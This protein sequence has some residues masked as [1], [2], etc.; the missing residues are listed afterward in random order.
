M[1][2]DLNQGISGKY[3]ILKIFHHPKKLKSLLANK[4]LSP[5]YVRVKPTNRCNHNCY[6]CLYHPEFSGTHQSIDKRDKIP[7]EKMLEILDDFKSMGVKAVTYSGGGEP[8]THPNITE[9]LEE[10]LKKKIRLSMITN[11]QDLEGKS[12]ELL[13]NADWIRVSLDYHNDKL[14]SKIRQKPK[15]DFYKVKKN[16]EEFVRKKKPSCDLGVN[17]VI[18]E[19]NFEEL[20][21]IAKFCKSIGVNN[22]RFSPFQRFSEESFLD[23]HNKIKIRA[24]GQIEKAKE[25]Q[26]KKISIG[27]TYKR[28]F[29]GNDWGEKREY[30][31]CFYMEIVP[32]IA[33]DQNVYTCHNNAY[34]SF[35]KM[36]SIKRQSFKDMWFSTKT[37]KFFKNFNPQKTCNHE[38]SNDEKNKVLNEFLN[39]QE[40]GVVEYI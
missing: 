29:E 6:Y 32:V 8:L 27:S 24:I 9:F 23:Y 30:P 14:F 16:L 12:A 33:A 21:D 26:D 5:L 13:W 36:G 39:C 22:L 18:S 7:R 4:V 25:L 2:M 37:S 34:E 10:T 1:E 28:Y 15:D 20:F 40:K 31:R 17:C 11:G 35:G 19:Y 38:C 3:S